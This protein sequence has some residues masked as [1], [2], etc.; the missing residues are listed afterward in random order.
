MKN[1]GFGVT[2]FFLVLT[3][4]AVSIFANNFIDKK[5]KDIALITQNLSAKLKAD[6]VSNNV[7]VVF[8]TIEKT[9][10]SNTET[11]VKGDALAIVPNDNTQLPLTFEAKVNPVAEIVDDVA[12]AF[13]ESNYA[14]S[15]DEEFLMKHLLKKL[16]ADYKTEEVVI[17]IEGFDTQNAAQNQKEYKGSAE[18]RVGEVEWKKINFDVMMNAKNEASKVEYNLKN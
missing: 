16:A 4:S 5:D 3:F 9:Q 8:K 7:S 10:V 18:I 13:I 1:F 11:I 17:A 15:T 12:Y 14:P 6:L 2:N